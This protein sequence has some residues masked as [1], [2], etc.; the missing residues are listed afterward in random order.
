LE[1]LRGHLYRCLAQVAA[2]ADTKIP[3]ISDHMRYEDAW[4]PN[5]YKQPEL[6]KQGDAQPQT[7]GD[8]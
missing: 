3:R 1:M 5:A 6:I 7:G 8:P 4:Q 2:L